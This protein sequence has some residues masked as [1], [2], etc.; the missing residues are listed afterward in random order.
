MVAL[1]PALPAGYLPKIDIILHT[2]RIETLEIADS[3]LTIHRL[4]YE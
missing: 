3:N 1:S 2:L 4:L